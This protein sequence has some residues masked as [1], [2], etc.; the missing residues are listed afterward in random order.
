MKC[1]RNLQAPANGDD[2][3][4]E[5]KEGANWIAFLIFF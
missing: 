2:I 3:D 5:Q 4:G 1:L